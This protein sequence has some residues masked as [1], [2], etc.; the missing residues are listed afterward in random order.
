M[1]RNEIDEALAL[2]A[3]DRLV[4]PHRAAAAV[5]FSAGR[6]K[7]QQRRNDRDGDERHERRRPHTHASMRH[8]RA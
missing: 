4:R 3:G 2:E 8:A 7:P 1:S 6:T 5:L